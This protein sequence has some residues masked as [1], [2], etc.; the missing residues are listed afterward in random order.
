MRRA[1]LLEERE[2]VFLDRLIDVLGDEL[3]ECFLVGADAWWHPHRGAAA[4]GGTVGTPVVEGGTGVG[5]VRT[6]V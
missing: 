5:T 2:Q 4:V 1:D 6:S 3:A